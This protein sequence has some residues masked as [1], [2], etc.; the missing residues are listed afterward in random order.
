MQLPVR[1]PGL[2][3]PVLLGLILPAS[4]SLANFRTFSFL[5]PT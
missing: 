4:K 3:Q 5:Y 1:V 2:P